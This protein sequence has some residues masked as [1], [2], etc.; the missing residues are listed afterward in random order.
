MLLSIDIG[1][2]EGQGLNPACPPVSHLRVCREKHILAR[3]ESL[4]KQQQPQLRLGGGRGGDQG[5]RGG[6]EDGGG[7]GGGGGGGDED[8]ERELWLLQADLAGLQ[9]ELRDS[10]S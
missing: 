1:S 6:D 4:Q 8:T 10:Q 7:G 5:D 3:L 2:T 9:V